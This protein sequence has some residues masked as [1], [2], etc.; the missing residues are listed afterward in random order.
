MSKTIMII[1][2]GISGLA[3]LHYLSQRHAQRPD[4]NIRLLEKEG[5]AGGTIQTRNV[6]GCLFE[7]GPN[8]FLDSKQRTL[9][10]VEDLGL[11]A[12]IVKA[13]EHAKIRCISVRD[14]LYALPSSPKSFLTFPP[15][16][17]LDKLRVLCEVFV[18]RGIDPDESV[19]A[20]GKRRLGERFSRLFLDPMIS[21]IYGG[22]AGRINL[23]AAF[24]R[25][26]QL[27][28]EF[29]SLFKAMIGLKKQKKAGQ[30][31]SAGMPMGT[32][33]SFRLG[34]TRFV[35]A[36]TRRYEKNICFHQEV[37]TVYHRQGR[38]IIS[39]G[40]NQYEADDLFVSMPAYRAADILQGISPPLAEELNRVEYAPIAVVGLVFPLSI[41]RNPPKGF[42]YVI[43]STEKKEVLGVLFESNI[44]PERCPDGQILFRVM[45]GGAR[46]PGIVEKSQEEIVR[47]A[48]HEVQK[49]FSIASDPLQTMFAAWPKA[50]PQ[51]TRNYFDIQ[52]G[53]DEKLK[54]WSRLHLVANYRGGVSLNDCIENAY[55]A[56]Q[57]S[58][59]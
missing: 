22:D 50:I 17:P 28:Q 46:H 47:L 16:N 20:F 40:D 53:L 39:S 7:T 25:I 23:R 55:Q 49:T 6:D 29:G 32:L 9:Y 13:G 11:S 26:Y 59:L 58:C 42:G 8:G 41:F 44:F 52:N 33:T 19:Y 35:E 54:N 48:V 14:S 12:E 4:I 5:R 30:A 51:Y 2:G 10:L 34:Q 31:T 18:P 56:A 15:L 38:F 21:G 1:G 27:E 3:L 36:L 57:K 45:A 43:P 24:P 37:K